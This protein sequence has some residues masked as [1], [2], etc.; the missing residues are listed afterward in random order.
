MSKELFKRI[1]SSIILFP[2]T[3]LVIIEGSYLFF[4][5]LLIL[6]LICSYEWYLMSQKKKYLF[7][8]FIFLLISF[9]CAYKLR[10]NIEGEYFNFLFITVICVLTDIGG[11]VFGKIFKGPT[12]TKY[13][14]NKTYSGVFGSYVFSIM[15]V[16]ILIKFGIVSEKNLLILDI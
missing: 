10:Y 4:I 8:G 14:P 15:L 2:V 1:L 13:S 6:F 11:Y 9:F 12:L 5:F 7:F 16:P 3:I